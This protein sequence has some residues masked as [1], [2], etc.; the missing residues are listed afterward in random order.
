[1][2]FSMFKSGPNYTKLKTNLRIVV[3]RLKLLEKKR[4]ELAQKS[5]TEIADYL[6][7]GKVD[8][9]KVRV[10]HIIREDYA[11][12]AMERIEMYA[13]MLLA[14]FGL[15]ESIKELDPGLEESIAS[16]LWATPR[17]RAEVPEISV[18][19]QELSAKYGKEF[20]QACLQNALEE[21]KVNEKLVHTMS[22]AVPPA[23]LVEKYLV[24]I[25]ATYNVSYTP[26][27]TLLSAEDLDG[28]TSSRQQHMDMSLSAPPAAPVPSELYS[29]VDVKPNTPPTVKTP[30][31]PSVNGGGLNLPDVP[32][33]RPASSPK[34]ENKEMNFD[35]LEARFNRLKKK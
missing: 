29:T 15:I 17:L 18:V 23:S 2:D 30:A 21:V 24:V 1:M 9:A 7:S 33:N 20:T 16:I 25:A 12:E 5:R 13:D 3:N 34:P 4:T 31:A 28:L 10:E 26:D 19:S 22:I 27:S 8:R 32:P 11:V 35:D 6:R 14:R